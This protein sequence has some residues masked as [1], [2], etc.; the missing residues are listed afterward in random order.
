MA[1]QGIIGVDL[2]GTKVSVGRVEGSRVVRGVTAEISAEE[3]EAWVLRRVVQA[4]KKVFLPSVAG[5]GVGVPSLVDVEEGIV[6]NVQNIPSWKRVPLK[7]ILEDRF[8]RPVLV[9]NDANCFAA[10]EKYFGKGKKYQNL[11]GLTIGTGLGAGIIIAGQLYNGSNCGAGEFGSIPYK[12]SILEHYCSGQFFTGVH[13]FKGSELYKM[14]RQGDKRAL[15]IFLEFG[16]HLGEAV[17]IIMLAVDPEA[18]ILGGS[19]SRAFPFFE[20]SMRERMKAFPYPHAVQRLAIETSAEP[21]IAILGA[22]AL[23]LNA[24]A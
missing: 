12:D 20:E 9:N 3:S 22:A 19:V 2:G 1:K 13:G 7:K 10:G 8:H 11:V 23:F 24:R 15:E 6:Y 17:M 4:I 21:Q 18:I 16:G 14:A 5:I